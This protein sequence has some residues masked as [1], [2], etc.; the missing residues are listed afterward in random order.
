MLLKQHNK[1]TLFPE[2]SKSNQKQNM[3]QMSS[4]KP[5]ISK[6]ILQNVLPKHIRVTSFTDNIQ[7]NIKVIINTNREELPVEKT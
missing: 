3:Y 5:D 1:S 6:Y 2:T 4:Q 7:T